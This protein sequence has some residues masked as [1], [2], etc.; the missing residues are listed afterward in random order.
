[1]EAANE[2]HSG[3]FVVGLPA[4]Q[5]VYLIAVRYAALGGATAR[6]PNTLLDTKARRQ[7][8]FMP[9]HDAAIVFIL[10]TVCGCGISG[11]T[12]IA[13]SKDATFEV[14]VATLFLACGSS[15]SL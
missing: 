4:F 3:N 7:A 15:V 13:H 2:R 5:E 8:Q 11:N 9:A 6:A 14:G 10:T 1:M 12:D